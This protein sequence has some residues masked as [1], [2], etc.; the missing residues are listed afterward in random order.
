MFPIK[1][2]E[3]IVYLLV[4]YKVLVSAH[5]KQAIPFICNGKGTE[6]TDTRKI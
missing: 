4:F 1:L 3:E 5:V 2:G 6:D